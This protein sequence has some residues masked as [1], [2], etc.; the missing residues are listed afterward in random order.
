MRKALTGLTVVACLWAGSAVF[1]QQ[2]TGRQDGSRTT[3]PG[4]ESWYED[5]SEDSGQTSAR[6]RDPMQA[7]Q[8]QQPYRQQRSRDGYQNGGR[9]TDRQRDQWGQES[10]FG[11]QRD[12]WGERRDRWSQ[13]FGRQEFQQDQ[14]G[15]MTGRSVAVVGQVSKEDARVEGIPQKNQVV[16]LRT[17]RGRTLHIDLGEQQNLKDLDLSSDQQILVRGRLA[18]VRGQRVLVAEEVARISQITSIQ[19][20]WDQLGY[21]EPDSRQ[22]QWQ[23]RDRQSGQQDQWQQQDGRFGQQGTQRQGQQD[24]WR[25]RQRERLDW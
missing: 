6:E 15:A 10:R 3:D 21:I 19:R 25:Q 13:R 5:R 20:D 8:G 7:Q 11:Q 9:T 17:R 23:Q 14:R 18:N 16:E 12:Q 22:G 4:Y 1:A 24:Q 2:D